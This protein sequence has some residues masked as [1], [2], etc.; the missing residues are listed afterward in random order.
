METR[1]SWQNPPIVSTS[2]SCS[3]LSANAH[4]TLIRQTTAVRPVPFGDHSQGKIGFQLS[5]GCVS[6]CPIYE[7]VDNLDRH[8]QPPGEWENRE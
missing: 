1:K 5:V 3:R 7:I 2:S 6:P 4:V 8:P